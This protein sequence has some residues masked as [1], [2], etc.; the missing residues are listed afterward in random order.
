[1]V[2]TG[3]EKAARQAFLKHEEKDLKQ[4]KLIEQAKILPKAYISQRFQQQDSDSH[5]NTV[6]Q[7]SSDDEDNEFKQQEKIPKEPV[8]FLK[9][10]EE[11]AY[12]DA[13]TDSQDVMKRSG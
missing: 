3:T 4:T 10:Q 8:H 11:I 1:M 5:S 9:K 7:Q 6:S 13:I 12:L 2:F